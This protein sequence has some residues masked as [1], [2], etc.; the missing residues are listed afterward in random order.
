MELTAHEIAVDGR[1]DQLVPPTSLTASSGQ[2][3]F[4]A[5][6]QDRS[7]ALGLAVTGRLPLSAG[8]IDFTSEDP[9]SL[10]EISALIDAPDVSAPIHN[11]KVKHAAAEALAIAGRKSSPTAVRQWLS[12]HELEALADRYVETLAGPERVRL[13][14]SLA[15]ARK[16]VRLLVIDTPDRHRGDL[17]DWSAIAEHYA[18]NGYA[19]VVICD[20]R[21]IDLLGV[22]AYR[23]GATDVSPSPSE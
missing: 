20:Q 6:D 7:T 16:H 12:Q 1:H 3:T 10:A 5:C 23:I 22:T 9:G 18:H 21:S 11:L 8:R 13:L 4:V 19:V 15:V 17:R 2:C 14:A